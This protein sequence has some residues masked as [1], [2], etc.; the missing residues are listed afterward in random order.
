LFLD[1]L[2]L[3]LTKDIEFRKEQLKQLLSFM[4]EQ[5]EVLIDALYADLHRHKVE[6]SAG[7]IATIVDECRY[8]IKVSLCDKSHNFYAYTYYAP[9]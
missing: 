3:G 5:K 8:M 2:L 4:L 6:S 7:E 9:L 1:E